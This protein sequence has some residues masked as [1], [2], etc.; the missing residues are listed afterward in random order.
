MYRMSAA[1]FSGISAAIGAI[2]LLGLAL[3]NQSLAGLGEGLVPMAPSTALLF[4][5]YG[6]AGLLAAQPSPSH[7]AK[8]VCRAITV[9]GGAI[10][11]PILMLSLQGIYLEIERLGF[12]PFTQA[13]DVPIG[14]MSPIGAF[15][16][17]AV[18][19]ALLALQTKGDG[20][21]AMAA[22]WIAVLLVSGY[23]M[24]SLAY[25]LGTPMFYG[26]KF[27][28]PAATTS[29]AFMALGLALLLLSPVVAR[30]DERKSFMEG[31]PSSMPLIVVFIFLVA[32]IVAA[33]HF[34]HR[35]H[36]KHY[37]E[38]VERRLSAIADLKVSELKRWRE[39]RLG[40]ARLFHE[41]SAFASLVQSFLRSPADGRARHDLNVWLGRISGFDMVSL[42]DSRFR[43]ALS[44]PATAPL[45]RRVLGDARETL[46][47]GR[48]TFTDFYRNES[49]DG[50]HIN[51]LVPVL[52]PSR[53]GEPAAVLVMRAD[54]GKFISPLAGFWPT[55]SYSSETLLVRRDGNDV[56]FLN[57]L[58][59]VRNSALNL[60]IPLGNTRNPA[61]MA[62]L[63][64]TG[65]V[66]GVDYRGA[67]VIAALRAIPG[68]PWFLVSKIDINEVNRPL[69]ERLWVTVA[70]VFTLLV[71]AAAGV[72]LVWRGQSVSFLLRSEQK[73]RLN[74]ERL[75]CLVN[76][77]Q[78]EAMSTQELLDFALEESLRM[79][80][81]A[82][83][84]IYYYDEEKQRFILN[85]WSHG[86]MGKCSVMDP[87]TE[88]DLD[89]TGIWGEA[90]R[91]RKVIMINDFAAPDPLKRGYPE[92]HVHLTRFLTIPLIERGRIMA[93]VGVANKEAAYDDSDVLQLSL[94]MD[95][96]WKVAERRRAEEE[97]KQ[98][99]SEL[100]RFL[101]T[102][103]HDLKSPLVTISSF[104]KYLELDIVNAN[105]SRI[106]QDIGFIR[107]AADRM[108]RLL[109]ELLELSRVGRVTSTPVRTDFREIIQEALEMVAGHISERGVTVKVHENPVFLHGDRMRLVEIWQN[110]LENAVKYMGDQAEP[111]IEAGAEQSGG[112]TVFFVRDNGIGIEAKFQENVFGLFNKLDSETEGS[113]LGL[114]L[115]RRIVEMYAGRIWVES[116]G[117]GNGSCFRFTLPGAVKGSGEIDERGADENTDHRG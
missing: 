77:F 93:V 63:G 18:S 79:T 17:L 48:V 55:E 36:E 111:R 101:Y 32:G 104:L 65:I 21:R 74:R 59:H 51:I 105:E 117:K 62:V 9:I 112:L 14:H 106:R 33:G 68:S 69:Q 47:T 19:V 3:G 103:S 54:P 2:A 8:Q 64:R 80:S 57:D 23:S 92:G 72:G 6:V 85:S 43:V 88:Y 76:V 82:Y 38:E 25:L 39:E 50:M 45:S 78:Y 27:I 99:N 58:R 10:A 35:N 71:C 108:G 46:R 13:S 84:Y 91:Q 56:L 70:L 73:N 94:L 89:R 110:L 86:V 15:S 28:P 87:Q 4:I 12:Q 22:F 115:V 96:V 52:N 60:R 97:L 100:E 67:E 37:Q 20:R 66:R 42:L 83:G 7:A 113:G 40:D 90:V 114:A 95:A 109:S 81:S 11:L 116:E 26:G 102:A 41:N 34:Y 75:Q 30:P 44:A 98:K 29:L 107:S 31:R 53:R 16:F 24:L 49:N 61:V 1:I 5:A